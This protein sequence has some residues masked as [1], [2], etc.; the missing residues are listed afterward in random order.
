M[1]TNV[2]IGL[3]EGTEPGP[4]LKTA[5]S[6]ISGPA[7]IHL[8]SLIRA[9]TN[10]D[11]Q[12][13]LEKAEASLKKSAT[14]LQ[15]HGT[16]VTYEVGLIVAAAAADLLRIADHRDADLMVIGLAKRSRV[17]KALMGSDAQ[18]VLLGSSCPVLVTR[19]HGR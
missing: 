12:G 2:V 3:K 14:R 11:E 8:V 18:R 19:I 4:L 5:E 15:G 9:G 1:F 13:R 16:E 17:G 7:K 6:A 10:E